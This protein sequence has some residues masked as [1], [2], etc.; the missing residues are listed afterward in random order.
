MDQCRA[1]AARSTGRGRAQLAA[2]LPHCATVPRHACQR[3]RAPRDSSAS[4]HGAAAAAAAAALHVVWS[5]LAFPLRLWATRLLKSAQ[6][7]C[8]TSRALA[9]DRL[10]DAKG[11]GGVRP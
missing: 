10:S 6:L 5:R 9:F 8:C 3:V 1:R 4:S 7:H 11:W 2:P